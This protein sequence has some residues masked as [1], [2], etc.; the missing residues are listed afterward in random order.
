[1]TKK[2]F[3]ASL[4]L[5][6]AIFLIGCDQNENSQQSDSSNDD[7]SS[8][9]NPTYLETPPP[10]F[11]GNFLAGQFAQNQSD[12]KSAS[13]YF[14]GILDE[15][16][17][18]ADIQRRVMAL[19]MGAG[20]Y[21]K[22]IT[23][24]QQI[25][26]DPNNSDKAL[27]TLLVSLSQFKEGKFDESIKSLALYKNDA[28]G[29]AILPLIRAWAEAGNGK[30]NLDILKDSPS[31]VYQA[32][33]ISAYAKDT[34]AIKKLALNNDFT[35]T[36]TPIT[37]LEDVAAIFAYYNEKNEATEIYKAL[38][39][40]LPARASFYDEKI[41]AIGKGVSIALPTKTNSPQ[42]GLSEAI[43]DM[44]QILSNGYSDSSRLFAHMS[45]FLNPSNY[46]AY[47]LLAEISAEN[48]LYMEATDF[49]SKIDTT[50]SVDKKMQ[51]TRQIAFLQ[52]SAGHPDEAI[53]ILKDLV[54]EKN[55]VDA[56]VQIGDIYRSQEKFED[57]LKAY[58]KA[59]EMLDNTITSPY[60]EL[61]F[62]RGIVHE[63]L[64][65]WEM[66]EKDLKTALMFQPDEPYVLNYLGYSWADQGTNLD[67]AAEMIEKAVRLK[68]DDG[69][70]VDSLGW[71]YFR[72]GQFDKAVTVLEKA[73]QLAP[74]EPEIND[75][76][77]DAYWRVG[78]KSEAR[79]Q[80]SRAISFTKDTDMI[81]KIQT[82]I[83]NGL[84]EIEVGNKQIN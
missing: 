39:N 81:S 56:Q 51:V 30:V 67:K 52:L 23:L 32:V 26:N 49:L 83:D 50:Q 37:R 42:I 62:A 3:H 28:L 10:S 80:W 5:T 18:H 25:F 36:P 76:L 4:L 38:K 84:P 9:Y 73:S 11:S 22:A 46:A 16:S 61:S 75:H 7:I 20:H 17:T 53:R 44:A 55:N 59:F 15:K 64:K 8:V 2:S 70:I 58:D 29:I 24:A 35:K 31:L 71:I 33:L 79:F 65:N 13:T 19:Q 41:K 63:R 43:S 68:P 82:K 77:G 54:E 57:A 45:L 6:T 48:K 27:S 66:A 47:E 14:S 60:W 34:E 74:T 40:G 12:W 72:M 1:M 78:R 69:A 21:D